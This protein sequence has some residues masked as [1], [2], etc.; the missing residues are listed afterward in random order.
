MSIKYSSN[1]S[2]SKWYELVMQEYFIRHV[3]GYAL[4]SENDKHKVVKCLEAA[5][6]RRVCEVNPP[7][8]KVMLNYKFGL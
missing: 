6:E 7:K 1:P 2:L 4:N 3:N 5:I 8:Q